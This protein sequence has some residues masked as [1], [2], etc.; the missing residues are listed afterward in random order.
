MPFQGFVTG[1]KTIRDNPAQIKRW[2]RGAIRGL[3]FVRDTPEEAVD[4][5][6]KRLQLGSA[7]RSMLLEA[8]KNYVRAVSPG[9][10]GMPTAE[11]VK[12]FLEYD[13]KIPLQIKEDIAPERLLTL[14]FVEEV[15][16]ELEAARRRT[17]R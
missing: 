14:Q 1:E 5:G 12:N 16:K 17:P 8:V 11:G 13:I 9:V 15:K 7:T 4:L 3:M 2:L 6:I 10:P